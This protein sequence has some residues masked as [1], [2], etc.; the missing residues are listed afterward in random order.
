MNNRE[1]AIVMF[2]QFLRARILTPWVASWLEYF[3]E[4]DKSPDGL[5]RTTMGPRG[6]LQRMGG[7]AGEW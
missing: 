4:Q 7:M 3:T 5:Y 6:C 2:R 1:Q